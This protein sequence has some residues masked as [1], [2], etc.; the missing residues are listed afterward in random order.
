[1]QPPDHPTASRSG[2]AHH[3][4]ELIRSRPSRCGAQGEVLRGEVGELFGLVD[5]AAE[6]L[7]RGVAGGGGGGHAAPEAVAGEIGGVVA[8]A[9]HV[10][11]ATSTTA[12]AGEPLAREV[13]V[14]VDRSKQRPLGGGGALEPAAVRA[15]RAG[16]AVGAVDDLDDP[17]GLFLVGLG[18]TGAG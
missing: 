12:W 7:G 5:V 16:P 14:A 6:G 10:A 8:E 11:L 2:R 4:K 13:A 3:A 15:H 9:G 18:A 17:A 1:M